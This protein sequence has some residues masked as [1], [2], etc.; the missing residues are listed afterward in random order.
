MKFLEKNLE[1]IIWE[2]DNVTLQKRGLSIHGKKLR[3]LKIGNFGISDII[4]FYKEYESIEGEDRIIPILK[5]T[6]YELKKEKVGISAFLQSVRYCKGIQSYMEIKH[7][8][9][10]YFLEIC[11]IGKEVDKSGDFIFITDVFRNDY[12]SNINSLNS[13]EFYSYDYLIDGINFV[14]HKGYNLINKGF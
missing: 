10:K 14:N 13:I 9:L 12:A 4:T 3:Q 7:P 11:L 6:V 8:N 2:A 1:D 5:I